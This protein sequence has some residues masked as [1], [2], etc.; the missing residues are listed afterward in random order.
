MGCAGSFE[1][2]LYGSIIVL[3]DL[4]H[5]EAIRGRFKKIRGHLKKIR[6]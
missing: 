2:I 3:K 5:I 1:V 6:G 4:N